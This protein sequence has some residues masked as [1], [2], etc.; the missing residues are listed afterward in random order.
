MPASTS[1]SLKPRSSSKEAT[2]MPHTD[3][4][5][6]LRLGRDMLDCSL[7]GPRGLG[8]KKRSNVDA[9]A[10][11]P[12]RSSAFGSPNIIDGGS[13]TAASFEEG[14]L[15]RGAIFAYNQL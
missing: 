7:D 12:S 2:L 15:R 4:T 3:E 11:M 6:S 14:R 1:M 9:A 13:S 8:E 5:A 10:T